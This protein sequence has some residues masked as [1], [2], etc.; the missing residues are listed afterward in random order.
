METELEALIHIGKALD[1]VQFVL[2]LMFL[3]LAFKNFNGKI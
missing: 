3:V 1:G 2:F